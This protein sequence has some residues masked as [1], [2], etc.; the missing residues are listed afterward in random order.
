MDAIDTWQGE[1]TSKLGDTSSLNRK[2]SWLMGVLVVLL[3]C[4]VFE[5]TLLARLKKDYRFMQS[6]F[7]HWVPEHILTKEKVIKHRF[8]QS[9]ILP[10]S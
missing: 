1:F 5:M 8:Y 2:Y 7:S 4:V 6:V 10:S 9:G 3:H